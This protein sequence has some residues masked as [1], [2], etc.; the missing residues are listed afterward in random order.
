MFT[1]IIRN[2]GHVYLKSGYPSGSGAVPH[3]VLHNWNRQHAEHEQRKKAIPRLVY[4]HNPWKYL[5]TKFNLWQLRWL[6]DPEFNESEFIEGSKQAAVVVTDI[7]RQQSPEKM[8]TYTTP[9]GFQQISR[10]M[11]LSRNDNRLQ[12]IRFQRE[13]LRRAIPMK[14]ARRQSFG[15]R[16]AFID[17]L[18]VGLRNTKDFDS[19]SEVVEVNELVRR[20]DRELR[21][22]RDVVSVPHR[23]VFAEIF[24]RFRRDYTEDARRNFE[25]KDHMAQSGYPFTHQLSA[26]VTPQAA[27]SK[28]LVPPPPPDALARSTQN[29][30][31]AQLTPTGRIVPRSGD[32]DWSVSFYKILTFDVLNYDPDHKRRQR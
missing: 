14:V 1:K 24:I 25:T 12:L 7:I 9:V 21:T 5:L 13:H 8:S 3:R 6:W 19:A 10:D 32:T 2:C 22:P 15:R 11:L 27:L 28:S 20:M 23:I 29:P 18:F 30:A 26:P 31:T 16:Y 4:L 17:V